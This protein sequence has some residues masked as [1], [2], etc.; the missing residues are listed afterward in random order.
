[1]NNALGGFGGETGGESQIKLATNV[2]RKNDKCGV[3]IR[4]KKSA[5]GIGRPGKRDNSALD[6][7]QHRVLGAAHAHMGEGRGE[8]AIEIRGP[9]RE[10]S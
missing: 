7:N 9:Q 3:G 10:G 5:K 8:E 6:I 1:M 2:K 4:R